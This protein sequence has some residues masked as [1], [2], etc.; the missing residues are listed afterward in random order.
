MK[1][2]GSGGVSGLKGHATLWLGDLL[3]R[4][5]LMGVAALP[6]LGILDLIRWLGI[7]PTQ[8]FRSQETSVPKKGN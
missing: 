4:L 8:E 2:L 1:D 3:G 5:V 7:T 6:R